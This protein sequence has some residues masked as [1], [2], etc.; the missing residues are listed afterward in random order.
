MSEKSKG[1]GRPMPDA[2]SLIQNLC[3]LERAVLLEEKFSA[4]LPV[5]CVDHQPGEV[6]MSARDGAVHTMRYLKVWFEL[7]EDVYFVAISFLDRFLTR[8]KV[9]NF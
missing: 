5:T 2:G 6:S 8:M 9:H 3:E 1:R 7:P 4:N